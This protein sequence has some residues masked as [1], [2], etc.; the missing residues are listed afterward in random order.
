MKAKIVVLQLTRG[1]TWQ[2]CLARPAPAASQDASKP[3]S[4]NVPGHAYD[5]LGAGVSPSLLRSFFKK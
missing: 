4:S 1:L 3:A 2:I 5:S